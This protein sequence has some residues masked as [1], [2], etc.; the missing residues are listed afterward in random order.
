LV[1][2]GPVGGAFQLFAFIFVDAEG[3]GAYPG[4]PIFEGGGVILLGGPP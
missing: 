2:G 1:A 4:L 3:G